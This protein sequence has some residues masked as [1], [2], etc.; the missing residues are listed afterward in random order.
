MLWVGKLFGAYALFAFLVTFFREVIK[1]MEDVKGD[2]RVGCRTVPIVFGMDT[3]RWIVTVLVG[4]TIILLCTGLLVLYRLTMM[5]VFWYLIACNLLPMLYL[6]YRA[7]RSNTPEEYHI[8]SNI[9]KIIMV[10]GV[11]S[12]QLISISK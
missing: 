8:M 12:M 11:L 10:A 2:S 7:F 3:S 9:C 5:T 1:D 6:I 4:L